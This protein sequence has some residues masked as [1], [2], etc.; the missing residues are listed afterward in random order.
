MNVTIYRGVKVNIHLCSV[1]IVLL[2]V[3]WNQEYNV[4]CDGLA[5]DLRVGTD[6]R[7]GQV[8]CNIKVDFEKCD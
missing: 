3:K 2:T 8:R 7:L 4:D 1:G 5:Q 6:N